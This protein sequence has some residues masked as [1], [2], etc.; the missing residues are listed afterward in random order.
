M[1]IS[2]S[3]YWYILKIYFRLNVS[4]SSFIFHYLLLMLLYLYT[5]R[6]QVTAH[7]TVL[8]YGKYSPKR[9][10]C[11]VPVQALSLSIHKSKKNKMMSCQKASPKQIKCW[12]C[13]LHGLIKFPIF[14]YLPFRCFVPMSCSALHCQPQQVLHCDWIPERE[15]ACISHSLCNSLRVS[16]PSN[17]SSDGRSE[18]Q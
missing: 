15:S 10:L 12:W 14:G 9:N 5:G 18:L 2:Q 11:D 3:Q 17:I 7:E 13:V 4:L 6:A 8:N 1:A 16:F